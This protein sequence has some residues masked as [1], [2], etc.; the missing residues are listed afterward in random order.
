MYS[1]QVFSTPYNHFKV[2]SLKKLLTVVKASRAHIPKTGGNEEP[3]SDQVQPTGSIS[4]HVFLM[5]FP[6]MGFSR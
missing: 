2:M 6:N 4:G 1:V 5:T 3:L